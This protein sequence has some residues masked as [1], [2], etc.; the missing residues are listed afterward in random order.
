MV[1]MI[2]FSDSQEFDSFGMPI[3]ID[4]LAYENETKKV[5][6]LSFWLFGD[7]NEGILVHL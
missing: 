6:C 5:T 7:T 4:Y 3:G 1:G 2:E